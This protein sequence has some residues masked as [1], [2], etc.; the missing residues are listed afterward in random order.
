MQTQISAPLQYRQAP[1]KGS[2][3]NATDVGLGNHQETQKQDV[4]ALYGGPS[5]AG[6]CMSDEIYE[7]RDYKPEDHAFIMSTFL[8]GLYYGN[9]FFTMM[10][11]DLFM[12]YYKIVGEALLSK[13]QVKVACL[14][15]EVD[16]ILGYSIMSQDFSAVHWVFVKSAFRKQ[17]ISTRLL[18]ARPS[19]YTHFGNKES[20]S[21][22][23]RFEN[24]VFNPFNV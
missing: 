10:P 18:P 20:L 23:K 8:R 2:N 14:K 5:K 15:D 22:I 1:Q 17:G 19:C 16:V 6:E 13:S 24:C 3:K 12:A 9:G 11:K 7:I 21:F 4:R